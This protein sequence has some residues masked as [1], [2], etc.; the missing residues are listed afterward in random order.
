[1]PINRRDLLKITS[2]SGVALAGG[3]PGMRRGATQE[4]AASELTASTAA[5]SIDYAPMIVTPTS[6]M[7]PTL[8]GT[9]CVRRGVP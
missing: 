4:G 2:A 5:E 8:G 9:A 6:T 1:M 7:E 3:S